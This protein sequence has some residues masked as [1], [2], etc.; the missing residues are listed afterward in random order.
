M[1]IPPTQEQM[2]YLA[3]IDCSRA[4]TPQSERPPAKPVEYTYVPPPSAGSWTAQWW[5]ICIVI[6]VLLLF[7]AGL[8]RTEEPPLPHGD[9]TPVRPGQTVPTCDDSAV[10]EVKTVE[11]DTSTSY[12]PVGNTVLQEQCITLQAQTTPVEQHQPEFPGSVLGDLSDDR[13]ST[14]TLQANGTTL[15]ELETRLVGTLNALGQKIGEIECLAIANAKVCDSVAEAGDIDRRIFNAEVADLRKHIVGLE[16][17]GSHAWILFGLVAGLS[18]GLLVLGRMIMR[19]RMCR[20]GQVAISRFN[21][22]MMG[23]VDAHP[24]RPRSAQSSREGRRHAHKKNVSIEPTRPAREDV[25]ESAQ[26]MA[27]IIALAHKRSHLRLKPSAPTKPWGLGLATIKGNVRSENQDYGLCFQIG[28]HSVMIEADGCGALRHS[29]RGAYLAAVSA[30]ISVIKTY[31]TAPRWYTPSVE[32]VAARAIMAAARRL[33]VEGDRLNITDVRGGLRTTLIVAIGNRKK[34]GYS[35]IGDGGGYIVSPT[36]ETRQFLTPQ[37]ASNSAM[38]V[39]AASLGPMMQGEPVTG[40]VDRQAGDI[41]IVGTDGVFDRVEASFPADVLRGCIQYDGDLQ[42]TAEQVVGELASFKDTAGYV[43]DDNLTLGI[44]GSGISP[45]LSKGLRPDVETTV[46]E[47][48]QSP[49]ADLK[50]A[51]A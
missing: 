22:K 14:T 33:A 31:G 1:R 8:A 32:H 36:G 34:L 47:E 37:K 20:V 11:P 17:D 35:Y 12:H 27:A 13:D 50:E 30:A 21:E 4:T 15:N 39:L 29:Q 3:S 49:A 44:M 41:V 7:L 46:A 26:Q 23:C 24:S 25:P 16:R 2:D 40:M 51:T 5:V 48:N 43:C 9:G 45:S 19:H 42:R 38:N 10:Q 28:D 18:V 6:L